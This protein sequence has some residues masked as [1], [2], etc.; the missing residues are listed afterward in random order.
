[1]QADLH[2]N[3]S[4]SNDGAHVEDAQLDEPLPALRPAMTIDEQIAALELECRFRQ[5]KVRQAARMRDVVQLQSLDIRGD[6]VSHTS[7]I[8]GLKQLA[9]G[10]EARLRELMGGHLVELRAQSDLQTFIQLRSHFQHREWG[11]LKASYPLI[12]READGEAE[13]LERR[14]IRELELQKKRT[15]G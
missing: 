6:L 15:R 12:F 4:A 1:M 10:C 13:R 7:E 3:A 11:Y 14:L 2:T 5:I 9:F 8:R